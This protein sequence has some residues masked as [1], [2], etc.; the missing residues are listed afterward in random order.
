VLNINDEKWLPVKG[1]EKLYE[2]S[3]LGNIRNNRDKILK[4]YKINSGY[5]AIKFT[6]NTVRT[7]ALV[8]RVVAEAFL[9][10]LHDLTEVNH[11]DENKSNN[12]VSNLEWVTSSQNKQHSI[13]S[14]RYDAI[15][16]TKNTLGIKHKSTASKYH[17]VSWDNKRHKWIAS[18]RYDKKT[19]FQ[20]R[21]TCE[22]DAA[23]HVNWIIDELKLTDRPKNIV[24]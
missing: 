14:G 5:S 1:F 15:F 3:N 10:S 11:I 19:Y 12:I 22:E 7:H 23:K 4:P 13:K 16:T 20:K 6:Y 8:H 17:N 24:D 9:D 18:V 21:F 2:V